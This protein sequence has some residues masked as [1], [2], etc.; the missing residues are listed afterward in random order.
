MVLPG[1]M[2]GKTQNSPANRNGGSNKTD[3]MVAQAKN[4]HRAGIIC[5]QGTR[6]ARGDTETELAR[7]CKE[8]AERI[9]ELLSRNEPSPA[10]N[11]RN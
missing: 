4:N 7:L 11:P 6:K 5:A 10:N 9:I 8:L 1:N 3:S 2:N